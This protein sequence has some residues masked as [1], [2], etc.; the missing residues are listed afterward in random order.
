MP[1]NIYGTDHYDNEHTIIK[2]FFKIHLVLI[3]VLN[4]EWKIEMFDQVP[5]ILQLN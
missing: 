2:L 1:Y 4:F 5:L 3:R